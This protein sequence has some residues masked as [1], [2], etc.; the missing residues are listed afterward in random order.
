MEPNHKLGPKK[1]TDNV[2]KEIY[3][4]LKGKLIY[5]SYKRHDIAF[6]VIVVSLFMH[7]IYEI[8]IF[9]VNITKS[10]YSNQ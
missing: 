8:S 4:C 10:F 1:D 9:N 2:E 3:Q 6:V 7:D 5:M